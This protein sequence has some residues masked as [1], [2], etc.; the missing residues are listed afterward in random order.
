MKQ[1]KIFISFVAASVLAITAKA[2]TVAGFGG[3]TEFTQIANNSQLAAQYGKQ[4]QQYA[5]QI[6]Q[7]QTAV[8]QFTNQVQ[9]YKLMLQN[10]GQLP[11][12]QWNQFASSVNKMRQIMDNTAGMTY[13]AANYDQMFK[14]LY[15]KY[16]TLLASGQVDPTS[17]YKS[18]SNQ[19]NAT[20]NDSLKR[21]NLTQADLENDVTTMRELQN[22]S[23]SAQGQLGAIQ[24]ANEI[25]LHQTNTLKKLQ[26]TMMLQANMQAQAV[27]ADQQNKDAV[28]A[29]EAQW[30]TSNVNIA[31]GE[32][33]TMGGRQW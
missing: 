11:Q 33:N 16:D 26:Q 23:Q 5:T 21:L 18:L 31:P 10:I 29:Q 3:A 4:L 28:K 13:T 7:Y 30:G 1:S 6:Q 20:V 17:V 14:K 8:Q 27:A 19:T 32:G 9:S 12:T 24:A 2:G 22:V 25:A 15:P